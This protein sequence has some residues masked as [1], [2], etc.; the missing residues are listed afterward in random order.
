ME[1]RSALSHQNPR[2]IVDLRTA[3][4]ANLAQKRRLAQEKKEPAEEKPTGIGF[5]VLSIGSPFGGHTGADNP[6]GAAPG[7]GRAAENLAVQYL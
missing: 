2:A 1:Q 7:E 4:A 3:R 6:E 5:S